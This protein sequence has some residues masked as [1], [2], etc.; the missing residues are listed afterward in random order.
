L[1]SLRVVMAG[2]RPLQPVVAASSSL[3]S[4]LAF[5]RRSLCVRPRAVSARKRADHS[6]QVF[7]GSNVRKGDS[8][9][10]FRTPERRA[11]RGEERF[12]DHALR[13]SCPM[14]DYNLSYFY[15]F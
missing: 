13:S 7:G 15:V 1:P 5:G 14:P 12:S 2:K 6:M 3:D 8:Q 11:N 4:T 9:A 10:D